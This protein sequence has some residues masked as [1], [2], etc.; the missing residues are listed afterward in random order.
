MVSFVF[1]KISFYI[2]LANIYIEKIEYFEAYVL[3][4]YGNILHCD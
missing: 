4:K 2:Y 1:F 3:G